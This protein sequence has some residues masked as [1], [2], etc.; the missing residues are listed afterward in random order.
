MN[1][2]KKEIKL[3]ITLSRGKTITSSWAPDEEYREIPV[4]ELMQTC[5]VQ[6]RLT[7]LSEGYNEMTWKEKGKEKINKIDVYRIAF[8]KN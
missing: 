4:E 2:D 1:E 5:A 7:W 6:N 3:E 8:S